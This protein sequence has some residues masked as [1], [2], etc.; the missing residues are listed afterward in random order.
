MPDNK[1]A[2]AQK[3]LHS[4]RLKL[5]RPYVDFNYD[6]RK[7]LSETAKRKIKEYS[8]EVTALTNRPYQIFRPRKHAHLL[9]AQG[10]AQHERRLPGLKVAF[11]PTDGAS[12]MHVRWTKKGIV[13]KTKNVTMTDVKLSVRKLLADPEA[14]VNERIRGN[15]AKQ[16]TIQAGRY[17][18]PQPYLPQSVGKAV[19]RLVSRYSDN[20]SNHYFG[21]WLHGLKA[22]QFS[23]Q[24]TLGDY[25]REKQKRIKEGKRTRK[26][27]SRARVRARDKVQYWVNHVLQ[28]LRIDYPPQPR[29]W[30]RITR[31]QYRDYARQ[32]YEIEHD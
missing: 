4:A 30:R 31:E 24:G 22:Y 19:A 9:E 3:Q 11:L 28:R 13:A 12:K 17:E 27:S 2:R 21:R 29:N 15:P 25:L 14:H 32:G 26:N 23:E 16:Y 6:L 7:P 5:I 10:F 20:E 1:R 8:D 18:I